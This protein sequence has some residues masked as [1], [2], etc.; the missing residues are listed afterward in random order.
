M[1]KYLYDY[2]VFIF[3]TIFSSVAKINVLRVLSTCLHPI[4]LRQVCYLSESQLYSVQRALKQLEDEQIVS[5]KKFKN[6]ML[7]SLRKDSLYH[8]L[9]IR[10]FKLEQ[11]N[12]IRLRANGYSKKAIDALEFASSTNEFFQKINNKNK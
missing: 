7:Y 6:K 2:K 5:K 11:E 12:F 4:P 9:L 10:V 3:T 8:S 1:Y